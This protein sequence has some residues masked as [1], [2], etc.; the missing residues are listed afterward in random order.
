MAE[1]EF[2]EESLALAAARNKRRTA[3]NDPA[4]LFRLLRARGFSPGIVRRTLPELYGFDPIGGGG[5]RAASDG[6]DDAGDEDV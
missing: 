4:R 5:A 2:T 3:G 1:A 6:L